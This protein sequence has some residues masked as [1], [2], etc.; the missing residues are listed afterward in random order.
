MGKQNGHTPKGEAREDLILRAACQVIREKGFH[1]ARMAD[2]ADRAEISYGLAYHYFAN[3]DGVFDAIFARWNESLF[4][5]LD[6]IAEDVHGI[7]KQLASLIEYFL[8]AYEHQPDLVHIFITEFSRSSHNLNPER[9]TH[10]KNF[11]ARTVNLIK[12][13][14]E[15]GELR[16][17]IKAHY[18][19]YLFLGGLETFLSSMVLE[20]QAI[21]GARMKRNIKDGLLDLFLSGARP[22]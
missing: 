20:N 1:R 22:R 14:Q 11:I 7:E 6:R 4:A 2:I 8:D 18:L 12:N 16:T 21:D 3:K 5:E 13:A 15:N 17:D 19:A 10:F 9:L